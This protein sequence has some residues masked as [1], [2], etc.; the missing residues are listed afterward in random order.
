M[1]AKEAEMAKPDDDHDYGAPPHLHVPDGTL[2]ERKAWWK[3]VID[4]AEASP[5]VEGTVDELFDR[6][7][8]RGRDSLS[9]SKRAA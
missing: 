9:G 1:R 7:K 6:V 8:R 4:K 5:L 2:E 3:D